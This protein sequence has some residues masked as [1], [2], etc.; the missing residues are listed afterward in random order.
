MKTIY[1]AAAL[2]VALLVAPAAAQ[3]R[4]PPTRSQT[5]SRADLNLRDAR[6][7][8]RLD[9]RIVRAARGLC[10]EAS[11]LNMAGRRKARQCAD[12][13]VARV[14]NARSAAIGGA[15]ATMMAGR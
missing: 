4:A 1:A 7:V 6:D 5:V 13:A 14:A 12:A 2:A 3:D 8:A 11:A 10:G 9:L 15:T